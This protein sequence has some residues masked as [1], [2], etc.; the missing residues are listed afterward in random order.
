[1]P[2]VRINTVNVRRTGVSVTYKTVGASGAYILGLAGPSVL[3]IR[4]ATGDSV[5]VSFP[6]VNK[7]VDDLDVPDRTIIILNN[8]EVFVGPFEFDIYGRTLSS[9]E[10]EVP[11]DK[12]QRAIIINVS[13]GGLTMG[14]VQF[15]HY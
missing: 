11:E 13:A 1:M 15:S 10:E 4:N 9:G 14:A 12:N 3:H 6:I 2:R 5:T 7:G 8:K